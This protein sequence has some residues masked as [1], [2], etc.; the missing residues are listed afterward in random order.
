[1]SKE[2]ILDVARSLRECKLPTHYFTMKTWGHPGAPRTWNVFKEKNT[3]G[4]PA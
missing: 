2:R 4:T 1:M 3:C